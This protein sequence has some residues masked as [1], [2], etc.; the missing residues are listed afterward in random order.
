MSYIYTLS[1]FE[2][3]IYATHSDPSKGISSV[4][5]L[6]IHRFNIT[7]DS[8]T[9]ATLGNSRQLRV[10][11]KLSQPKG[12]RHF[13]IL[14][15]N[16]GRYVPTLSRE[17]SW[18]LCQYKLRII[19]WLIMTSSRSSSLILFIVRSHACEKVSYGKPGG[20]SHICLLSGSHKSRS[21]RCRTGYSL[22]PDGQSCKSQYILLIVYL[23]T[24]YFHF[25]SG[26]LN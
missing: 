8:K 15:V 26:I 5:L 20:C 2:D 12:K 16:V 3:Y 22:G 1:V 11:H 17:T 13:Y 7:V 14:Y 9:L 6:Q 25:G 10:Y 21:C 4:E 19:H 23:R 18:S 24:Y